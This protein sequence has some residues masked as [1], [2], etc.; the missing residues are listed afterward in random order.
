[1]EIR[2]YLTKWGEPV[3]AELWG[4]KTDEPFWRLVYNPGSNI[5]YEDAVVE[6]ELDRMIRNGDLVP[7][8]E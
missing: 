4:A 2:N 3:R 7:D 5:K 6:N 8:N 1:M